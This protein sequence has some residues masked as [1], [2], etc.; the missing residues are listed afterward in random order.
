MPIV[1]LGLSHHT[2]PVTVR[3][4]FAFAESATSEAMRKLRESGVIEEA[5]ILSTCNR[6]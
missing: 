5:V 3:E 4:R 2:A 1:A 6:V